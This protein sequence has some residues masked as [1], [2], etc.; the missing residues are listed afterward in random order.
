MDKLLVASEYTEPSF[1]IGNLIGSISQEYY[2][3]QTRLKGKIGLLLITK[4]LDGS[5]PLILHAKTLNIPTIIHATI[6]GLGGTK[7]EPNVP[8]YMQSL[9]VLEQL[10]MIQNLDNVVLRI[11]PLIPQVTNFEV[12]KQ[13]VEAA[14][15]FGITRCRTSVIDYY[16]FVR[17]KF[18]AH[19]IPYSKTFQPPFKYDLLMELR[20]ICIEFNMTLE[21]CAEHE[22]IPELIKVGCAN[23]EEWRRLGLN[24]QNGLP[25]RRDCFCNVTKYDLLSH[26]PT[27]G[28]N[29]LYCY[30]G[31]N[32]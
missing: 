8:T 25:K 10:N 18:E 27:C 16:P 15:S 1:H 5:S 7:L 12:I 28:Y 32:R 3:H 13:I 17:D 23:Q 24:L 30:W 9:D 11:D 21:S 6:T 19:K 14:S 31:K 22:N 4:D 20:E 2:C 29:C 26:E